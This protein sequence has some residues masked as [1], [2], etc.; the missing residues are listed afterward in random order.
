MHT[1]ILLN[2]CA[3]FITLLLFQSVDD[4]L[5]DIHPQGVAPLALGYA[6]VGLSARTCLNLQ[7]SAN[8]EKLL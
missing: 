2:D 6:L 5:F 8:L 4:M 3:T 7:S 1:L